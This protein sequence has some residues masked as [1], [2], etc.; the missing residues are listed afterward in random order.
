MNFPKLANGAEMMRIAAIAG[1]E[2]G[3]EVCAQIHDAFLIAAQLDRLD[4]HVALMR[5]LMIA[6]GRIVRG[7]LSIDSVS[8]PLQRRADHEHL[9]PRDGAD[10]RTEQGDRVEPVVSRGFSGV[11]GSW[12]WARTTG[13]ATLVNVPPYA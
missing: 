11:F 3:I 1:T 10:K 6:A 8:G 5:Q 7:G 4:E 9:D 12:E 2:A 13:V